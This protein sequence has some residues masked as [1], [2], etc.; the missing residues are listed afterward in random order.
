MF[1]LSKPSQNSIRAFI[2]A[3]KDQ[4][5]S[6][7]EVGRSRKEAPRGYNCDHNRV[8]LG[9]GKDV[10][11]RAKA[12]VQKWKMFDMP[13]VNLCWPDSPIEPG[14]TVVVLISHFGFWS[15]NACRIVYV[16]QEHGAL[17]RY[18]FAYGTLP[19]HGEI[20][21]ERFSVE[22]HADDQSV[23]YDILAFSRPGPL[24]RLGYPFTRVLQKRFAED[25]KVAMQRS[26]AALHGDK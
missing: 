23:W 26:V 12:A 1:L 19:Q 6:Y 7:A 2:A 24:A 14:T 18:G 21:E 4:Q 25:S 22:F 3:Q 17:E 9:T 5:F 13:W 8:Q 15:L 16:M 20:G 10:F 11:D